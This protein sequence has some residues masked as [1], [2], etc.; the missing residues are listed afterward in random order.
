MK[1]YFLAL[2]TMAFIASCQQEAEDLAVVNNSTNKSSG[3]NLRMAASFPEQIFLPNGFMP[4]GIES[5]KGSEF[6]V[7]SL[8]TGAIYKGDFRTG[9][10][11]ILVPPQAGRSSVGLAFDQRTDLLYVC[12]ISGRAFIYNTRTGAEVAAL[13]LT[14]SMTTFINDCFVTRDAVYFTDSF[15]PV[16]YRLPLGSGGRL[17][18][19]LAFETIALTNF[20]FIPGNFNGNGIVDSQDG[21]QLIIGNMAAGELYLVEPLT[22]EA[23]LI[24]LGGATVPFV[25]GLVL[26]GRMLYCVQNFLNQITV[27]QFKSGFLAGEVVGVINHPEFKIPSTA[28]LFGNRL[29][30]VNARFD[31]PAPD[32]TT[33]YDIIAVDKQK[34]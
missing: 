26:E 12:D 34:R 21:K 13:E 8:A 7:G 14:T 31:V 19:P 22:G 1:K 24:D 10:G 9:E 23:Q 5:G 32:A 3:E 28:T 11:S 30:A 29:Y 25:D 15:Q 2:F 17:L 18:W 33:E 16:Y 27:V 6:Y 20:T 4:E